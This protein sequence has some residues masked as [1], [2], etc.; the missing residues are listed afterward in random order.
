MLVLTVAAPR[1]NLL[2]KPTK[3]ERPVDAWMGDHDVVEALS[4]S[5]N[6][7]ETLCQ[8]SLHRDGQGLAIRTDGI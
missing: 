1:F 6:H 4:S 7:A 8:V 2:A 3:V 5:R